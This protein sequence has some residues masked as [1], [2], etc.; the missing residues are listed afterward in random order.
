MSMYEPDGQWW[1]TYD[2]GTV[3]PCEILRPALGNQWVVRA[4]APAPDA[5]AERYEP[6]SRIYDTH[7]NRPRLRA[8]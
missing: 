8:R 7:F 4:L 5:G 6:T 1:L 3:W 2:D